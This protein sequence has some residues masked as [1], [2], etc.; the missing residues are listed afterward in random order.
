[1]PNTK[2]NTP[3]WQR[4]LSGADRRHIREW[5]NGTLRDLRS[6]AAYGACLDCR[7]ILAKVEVKRA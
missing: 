3:K 2:K 5:C 4:K 6:Q 1:M 7:L